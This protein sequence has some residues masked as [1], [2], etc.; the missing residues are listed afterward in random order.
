MLKSSVNCTWMTICYCSWPKYTH[1]SRHTTSC[2][3]SGI[4]ADSLCSLRYNSERRP[5]VY[6]YSSRTLTPLLGA[7][8]VYAYILRLCVTFIRIF[9]VPYRITNFD[10]E[11]V[12]LAPLSMSIQFVSKFWMHINYWFLSYKIISTFWDENPMVTILI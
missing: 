2:T 9:A 1:K 4:R 11:F 5:F 7:F 8:N 6:S 3:I 10:S 12:P